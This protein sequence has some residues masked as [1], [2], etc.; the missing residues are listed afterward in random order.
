MDEKSEFENMEDAQ[1]EIHTL[2]RTLQRLERDNRVLASLGEN[3]E[4]MLQAF[5]TEK[6]LQDLYN[7]LLLS[8]TPNMIFL[9]NEA[10]E[11]VIGSEAS[12]R[13]T[14]HSHLE[15]AHR[16][17][18]R[19][20]SE[21]VAPEWV[22]KI[23]SLNRDVLEHLRPVRFHDTIELAGAHI[24][25]HITISPMVDRGG[26]CRGTIMAIND[27]SELFQARRHAEEAAKSK[28]SFL[29]NMSHEIRTPMNAI[30]GLS[31]LLQLTEL[32]QTQQNYVKNIVG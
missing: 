4:R 28:A 19:L 10:M 11:Y 17:M 12:G 2:R 21:Q 16:P 25:A 9:F 24:N 5:D 30:K 6:K 18:A 23:V 22:E 7:E 20:F 14:G 27:V 31:E 26:V 29:A 15:I 3:S 13:L 1:R 32:N 8:H